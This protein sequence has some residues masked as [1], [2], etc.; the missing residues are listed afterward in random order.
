MNEEAVIRNGYTYAAFGNYI[1]ALNTLLGTKATTV[2]RAS[3]QSQSN[4][5]RK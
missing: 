1:Y 2:G 4:M 3:T 5:V